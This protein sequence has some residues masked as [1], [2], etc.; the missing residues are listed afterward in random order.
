M[1]EKKAARLRVGNDVVFTRVGTRPAQSP[2][3]PD[4]LPLDEGVDHRCCL[5][6]GSE[7]TLYVETLQR[8]A[9]ANWAAR[10]SPAH[11]R[12]RPKCSAA[13][14]GAG[15]GATMASKRYAGKIAEDSTLPSARIPA[16]PPAKEVRHVNANP[17][18]RLEAV[19][20]RL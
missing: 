7:V 13:T 19:A 14:A 18:R 4:R 9:S 12:R 11:L 6:P 3:N 16:R 1:T 15:V 2:P 20:R 8:W 10:P 17:Q 5:P